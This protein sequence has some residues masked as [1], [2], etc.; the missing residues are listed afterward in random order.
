[1]KMPNFIPAKIKCYHE[2]YS[3]IM[4]YQVL[5]SLVFDLYYADIQ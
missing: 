3:I 4:L 5:D 1:M 2:L